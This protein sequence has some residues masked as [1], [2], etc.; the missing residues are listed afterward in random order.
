MKSSIRKVLVIL[1]AGIACGAQGGTIN[2]GSFSL[3]NSG[4]TGIA[5]AN[6]FGDNFSANLI[7]TDVGPFGFNEFAPFQ[8]PVPSFTF[9]GTGGTFGGLSGVVY[10]GVLYPA[11]P[12]VQPTPGMP[13][14]LLSL[15]QKLETPRPIITGPGTYDVGLFSV[16]LN[17]VLFDSSHT[18]FH[19]ETDTGFATGSITY[20]ASGSN[21]GFLRSNGIQAT[22][23]P[24]PSTW[25]CLAFAASCLGGFAGLRLRRQSPEHRL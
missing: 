6:V 18:I 21:N 23:I 7:D 2:S 10:N 25:S 4:I 16:S 12:Y 17:F 24:E 11:P 5:S 19:S 9:G 15:T 14:A 8:L 3:S 22:I 13:F 1:V 20:T